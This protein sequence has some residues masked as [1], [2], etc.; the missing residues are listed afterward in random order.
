M[1][2]VSLVLY[3]SLV[4][5]MIDGT[6]ERLQLEVVIMLTFHQF[7]VLNVMLLPLPLLVTIGKML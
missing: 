5:L 1:L 6:S 3:A 4:H 2:E 7:I